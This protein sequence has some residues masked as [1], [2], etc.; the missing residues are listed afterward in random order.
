MSL[1]IADSG[2][3]KTNWCHIDAEGNSELFRTEGINPYYHSKEDIQQLLQDILDN[4]STLKGVNRVYFYG[5]GCT[6]NY[7]K[8]LISDAL[9]KVFDVR[10]N[11]EVHS[12]LIGASKACCGD[13]EGIVCILGTGS[14]SGVYNGNQVMDQIPS[15]GFILGDEGSGSHIGK[16]IIQSYFYRE[17]PADLMAELKQRFDM[18]RN[19]VLDAVYSKPHPNRY[20]S[21]FSRF[22]NEF[23]EHPFI[24]RLVESAFSEF[25]DRHILYYQDS[26]KYRISF[27]GSVA[28]YNRDILEVLLKDRHLHLN[29]VIK[30]PMEGL[31]EYHLQRDF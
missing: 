27:V 13:E 14:N 4:K 31:V 16:K 18:S 29:K 19:D 9:E 8:K 10:I 5:A 12:D 7:R 20:V 3:T 26:N 15:L 25:I 24:K 2:S 6:N 17:M 30:D 11:V 22:S 28:H 1:L 23:R 21:D